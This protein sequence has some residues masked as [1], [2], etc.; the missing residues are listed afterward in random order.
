MNGTSLAEGIY[1]VGANDWKTRDF[2]HLVTRRGSS[3]NAFLI[4]DEKI[5]V[6][7]TVKAP[8]F[9]EMKE[10]LEQY[11]SLKDIS[12]IISLHVEPDHAGS[13]PLLLREAPQA[14]VITSQRFG[15]IGLSH[16][17]PTVAPL[18]AVAEGDQLSL[19]KRKLVFHL[20]PMVH[21][22]DNMM[23][24]MAEE[25]ILFSSDAFGQTI[26]ARTRFDDEADSSALMDE[27]ARYY[28]NIFMPYA[29]QV[30]RALAWIRGL[31]LKLIAP[32]HGF[33]WRKGIDEVLADYDR[34]SQGES[35][36]RVVV[37]Y[38]TIYGSTE[39]M[40]PAIVQGIT[41]EGVAA[42]LYHL[43]QTPDSDIMTHLLEAR[44]L[45]VGSPTQNNEVVPSVARLLSYLRGLRPK[46]KLGGAFGCYG[47]SGGATRIIL[48]AMKEG[49]MEI[50]E[51]GL[52]I[53][54]APSAEELDSCRNWGKELA[55]CVKAQ[56]SP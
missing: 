9:G 37:A 46:G 31:N 3:Y 53:K 4:L 47:W 42:S 15:E 10:R 17:F 51:P 38:D 14:Q 23:A 1:W 33:L 54:F 16:S 43:A 52:D 18:Q 49:G 48:E 6:I 5:T 50:I 2:H 41:S 25:G 27:T 44:A 34:W 21:F 36:P 55:R 32:A 11:I 45:V 56:S 24:Y 19:G 29:N 39:I 22:P 8:F 7:D 13:L 30:R 40:A 35:Q 12:Y 26:A 28:A 20:T